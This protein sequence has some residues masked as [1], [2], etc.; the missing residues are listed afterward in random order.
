MVTKYGLTLGSTYP[1][2]EYGDFKILSLGHCERVRIRFIT[3]GYEK[4]V[5]ASHATRGR[6][7]DPLYPAICGKG[8]VGVGDY[9]PKKNGKHNRSYNL[10]RSMIGRCY[11]IENKSYKS[12]GGKGVYVCD[13][14][15]NYQNFARWFELFYTKGCQLDKDIKGGCQKFY[16]PENCIFV[17]RK[18]N[19]LFKT[20]PKG[21]DGLPEGIRLSC[22]KYLVRVTCKTGRL[23][24]TFRELKDAMSFYAHHKTLRIRE[25]TSY[26]FKKGLLN[27]DTYEL[28]KDYTFKYK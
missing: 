7:K 28:L 12:Y 17:P 19:A 18:I 23:S 8:Y 27:K 6:V 11:D 2:R 4:F 14:W 10:W 21:K 15:H 26:H 1:S 22:G 5:Q 16:S 9:V 3:T 13:A 20:P 25:V 24:K